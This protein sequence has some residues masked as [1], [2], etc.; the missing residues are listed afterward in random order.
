MIQNIY[1]PTEKLRQMLDERNIRENR[2]VAELIN[3]VQRL[4]LQAVQHEPTQPDFGV[5]EGEPMTHLLMNRP[6]HP[7]EEV[8][9]PTVLMDFLSTGQKFN[10]VKEYIR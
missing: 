5:L 3:D 8:E 2:L 4:A 9:T 6:L 10:R 7:L 1:Q